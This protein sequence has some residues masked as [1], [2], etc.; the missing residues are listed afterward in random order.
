MIELPIVN[1]MVVKV[2]RYEIAQTSD[3]KHLKGLAYANFA[4]LSIPPHQASKCP[5]K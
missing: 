2:R 4:K 1:G 5:R 3:R